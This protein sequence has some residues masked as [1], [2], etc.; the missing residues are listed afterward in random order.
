M[1]QPS[2]SDTTSVNS[3]GRTAGPSR[4]TAAGTAPS[5]LGGARRRRNIPRLIVGV[6]LVLACTLLVMTLVARAGGRRPVVALARAVPAGATITEADLRTVTVAGADGLALVA[7]ADR[8]AVLGR[9]AAVP[10]AAGSLLAAGQVGAAVVPAA[11]RAV[12][13]IAVK[14]GQYPPRL[15][16][17][18]HVHLVI[19]SAVA[20]GP[21]SAAVTSSAP[22]GEGGVPLSVPGIVLGVDPAADG[23]AGAVVTVEV[24]AGPADMVAVA[25]G[26]G[27][28][29]VVQTPASG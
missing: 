14:A 4:P 28:V 6:V 9:P 25:A 2:G 24:S 16:A 11:G 29:G 7:E 20:T 19:G 18:D 12:V 22:P 5:R 21:A 15:T 27:Q 23:G 13:G 17:G 1:W 8:R 3:A 26:A 10:L